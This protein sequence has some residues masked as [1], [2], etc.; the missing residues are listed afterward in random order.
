M[1]IRVIVLIPLLAGRY[2]V[3]AAPIGHCSVATHKCRLHLPRASAPALLFEERDY[4]NNR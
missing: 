3:E 2:E 1:K 4:A